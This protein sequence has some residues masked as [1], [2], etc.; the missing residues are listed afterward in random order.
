M[1]IDPDLF[2]EPLASIIARY[3]SEM[4][5]LTRSG[6]C[7][8]TQAES[9]RK[10]GATALFR[11][12]RHP[13]AALSGLMLLMGCW[14]AS[15]QVA[16]E[17]EDREAAYWHAILHRMEPDAGNSAY[18]FRRTG[19]HPIFPDLHRVTSEI[20]ERR[21]EIGWRLKPKWDPLQ[22]IEWCEE[23]RK[24]PHSEKER[25]AREIQQAEW[26]LLFEWCALGYQ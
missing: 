26:E 1:A 18:W 12:A 19:E 10:A 23:A 16:Q 2:S 5:P 4:L 24:K 11:N 25:I 22:F 14:E 13:E 8:R 3:A 20:L 9:L 6:D 7:D 17:M 15:H 21:S